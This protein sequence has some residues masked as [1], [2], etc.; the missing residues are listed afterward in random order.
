MEYVQV[1]VHIFVVFPVGTDLRRTFGRFFQ[2]SASLR[3]RV[4][5]AFTILVGGN[6]YSWLL[7]RFAS[8]VWRCWLSSRLAFCMKDTLV[9]IMIL[10]LAARLESRWNGRW[11]CQYLAVILCM[12][13]FT[14]FCLT[15]QHAFQMALIIIFLHV[16]PREL[17]LWLHPSFKTHNTL[18]ERFHE[19]VWFNQ[20]AD[21]QAYQSDHVEERH[22]AFPKLN[23]R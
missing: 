19:L 18:G 22:N 9:F 16:A 10:P 23:G 8:F 11:W 15:L 7:T 5:R 21:V 12:K 20:V 13:H 14:G 2:M 17:C 3:S 4:I 1:F 6:V